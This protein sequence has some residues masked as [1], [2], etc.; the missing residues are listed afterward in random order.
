MRSGQRQVEGHSP[1]L[2]IHV[3]PA[4]L[5]RGA[6]VFARALREILDGEPDTHRTLSL[7]ASD[8]T[9]L[10]PDVALGV[11]DG[12]A[13]RK[14]FDP[15]A[16]IAL[17][18]ALRTM[19][20]DVVVA[21]GGEA[22]KYAALAR[23]KQAAL[24]YK[25]TGSS[26]ESLGGPVRHALYRRLAARVDLTAAVAQEAVDEAQQLLGLPPQRVML[27][28]NGR[29]PTQFRP[30]QAGRHGAPRFLWIGRLTSGKRPEWF[31]NAITRVRDRGV[32]LEG[33]VVGDGPLASV[34]APVAANAGVEILG[35][36]EDVPEL[37]EGADGLVFTGAAEGEGMPGVLIE[38]GLA[39]VPVVTTAVSG[40]AT[41]VVHGGTGLIVPVDDLDAVVEAV[42]HLAV[43]STAR[44][45][46]GTAARQRC[47]EHFTLAASARR[48]QEVFARVLLTDGIR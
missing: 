25:K 4:D 18:K 33:V 12:R 38:A 28:P 10:R 41:V 44:E 23:P 19:A 16:G 40:A 39:G 17:R 24:V 29:D 43:D 36:R 35:R 42:H 30:H 7:F 37:L 22:L 26:L 48:W 8:A 45:G 13:R 20:P 2:I 15:R 6:Q 9:H 21:H 46:M 34:L 47:L 32:D 27:A 14:G 5:A 31:L 1:A 11:P 3:L